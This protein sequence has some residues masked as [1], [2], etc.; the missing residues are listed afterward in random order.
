MVVGIEGGFDTSESGSNE[1][2]KATS[3]GITW[4][5]NFP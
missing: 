3:H 2:P 5:Y 4:Y 1:F